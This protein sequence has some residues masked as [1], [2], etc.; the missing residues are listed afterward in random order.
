MFKKVLV[1]EDMGNI[2][3]AVA[4]VLKDLGTAW[5]FSLLVNSLSGA[6]LSVVIF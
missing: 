3:Q 4:I 1:V 5:N 6:I 2:N